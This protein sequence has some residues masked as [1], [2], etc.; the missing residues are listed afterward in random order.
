MAFLLS[1]D[2][3]C[4]TWETSLPHD[5][6]ISFSKGQ[7]AQEPSG[8]TIRNLQWKDFR[9]KRR[10]PLKQSLVFY[11]IFVTSTIMYRPEMRSENSFQEWPVSA[12]NPFTQTCLLYLQCTVC[13]TIQ[14]IILI[15]LEHF[16]HANMQ[17]F[18]NFFSEACTL[19]RRCQACRNITFQTWIKVGSTMLYI[20][21]PISPELTDVCP[22]QIHI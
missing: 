18:I 10:I 7:M 6:F 19:Q 14:K 8:R 17:A 16:M 5:P 2:N 11:A 21:G 22:E 1:S 4:Q 13:L 12:S 20:Y 15:Y 9:R 3:F